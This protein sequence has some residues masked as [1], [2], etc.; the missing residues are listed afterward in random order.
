MYTLRHLPLINFLP[1]GQGES[2]GALMK[3][4]TVGPSYSRHF[5]SANINI[6]NVHRSKAVINLHHNFWIWS[7]EAVSKRWNYK[8]SVLQRWVRLVYVLDQWTVPTKH[9]LISCFIETFSWP[10]I[11][12]VSFIRTNSNLAGSVNFSL[13]YCLT[14]IR[15]L[16]K[17]RT[18]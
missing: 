15:V 8:Y 14:R 13:H 12:F 1:S 5:T 6:S 10:A 3:L 16:K 9:V 2:V 4:P 18:F 7:T 11:G 17:Q